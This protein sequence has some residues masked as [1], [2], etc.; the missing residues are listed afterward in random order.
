MDP[1]SPQGPNPPVPPGLAFRK[2]GKAEVRLCWINPWKRN[3]PEPRGREGPCAPHT[4]PGPQTFPVSMQHNAVT[5]PGCSGENTD[6]KMDLDV[7][8]PSGCTGSA[9]CPSDGELMQRIHRET[10]PGVPTRENS[11]PG[12]SRQETTSQ[13]ERK[14]LRAAH[15]AALGAGEQPREFPSL[16]STGRAGA[17]GISW[18]KPKQGQLQSCA[19]IPRQNKPQEQLPATLPADPARVPGSSRVLGG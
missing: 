9:P 12:M 5:K 13:E 2:T 15:R 6:L 14:V 3:F 11:S 19:H 18:D 4:H 16:S 8:S 10:C 17:A 1:C 7:G